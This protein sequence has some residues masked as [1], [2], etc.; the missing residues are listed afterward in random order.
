MKSSYDLAIDILSEIESKVDYLDCLCDAIKLQAQFIEE[1]ERAAMADSLAEDIVHNNFQI[2]SLV[3]YA[4]EK[5]L[6]VKKALAEPVI[7]QELA[8]FMFE[9][10]EGGHGEETVDPNLESWY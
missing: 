10:W 9:L 4:Q 5:I 8:D 7:G 2:Y 1:P 6:K 3:H